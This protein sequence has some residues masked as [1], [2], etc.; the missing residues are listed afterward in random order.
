MEGPASLRGRI[1][2]P[3][4][5]SI[6]HRALLLAA[7][8]E[9]NSTIRGLSRGEDVLHTSAAV[10]SLGALVNHRT[11][12]VTEV[13]GGLLREATQVIDVG[14]SGTGIRLLAGMVAALPFLTVLEGDSSLAGRPMGRVVRPLRQMGARIDGREDGEFPPLVVRG[15]GLHGIEYELPVPS[16]QVKGAI[17]LAGLGADGPTVVHE[18]LP[19]RAHTEEMLARCGVEVSCDDLSVRLVPG[20]VSPFEM[21]VPGDPSQGAFWIVA[22]CITPGSDVIVENLYTGPARVGYLDVLT[23]MGADL[24][25]DRDSGDVRARSSDLRGTV[26]EPAEIPGLVDEIPALAVAAAVASGETRFAGVGELRVK[27]SDRLEAIRTELGALGARVEAGGESLVVQGGRL[28]PASVRSH[29][30][31]RIAMAA[32]VAGLAADGVS[33]IEGWDC[34]ATSYPG[35]EQDLEELR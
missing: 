25:I 4:D 21:E 27:E 33:V 7:L 24:E 31:H 32:V 26:V 3:G 1:R 34:V 20:P 18:P 23:R 28:R 9:G 16:A 29:G 10:A 2:V 14:N 6:S 22:A 30:D 8:A 5:K 35:F 11:D 19:T 15:G 17:L 12:E 13:T